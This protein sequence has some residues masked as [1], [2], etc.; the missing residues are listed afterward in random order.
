MSNIVSQLLSFTIVF[1][2]ILGLVR[3]NRIRAS[4]L[5]FLLYLLL[6]FTSEV[7][8]QISI[9]LIKS[10]T[11]A[12]NIYNL[13]EAGMILYIFYAWGFL[14]KRRQLMIA[15]SVLF[16]TIWSVENLALGRL[17]D[18]L[19]SSSPFVMVY[20]LVMVL[21]SINEINSL[22]A[23]YS[24]HLFRNARF[25]ICLGFITIGVYSL[26]T[27]GFLLITEKFLLVDLVNSRLF[28]KIFS[29][30]AFINAFV[31][32]VYAIAVYYMPVRD[33]YYFSKRFK[34]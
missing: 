30:F 25:L 16:L 24:G 9:R 19:S 27:E 23:A 5:P 28:R 33:D 4:Y 29:L 12:L 13:L 34:A 32:I 10:N 1:P 6:A 26:I 3:M 21:L 14:R 11:I 2:L 31:N 20:S 22:I 7:V 17:E 8:S 18:D 15:L